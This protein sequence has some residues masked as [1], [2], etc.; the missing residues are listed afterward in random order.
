[1]LGTLLGG[2]DRAAEVRFDEVRFRAQTGVGAE[3]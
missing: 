1:V 2:R 3:T